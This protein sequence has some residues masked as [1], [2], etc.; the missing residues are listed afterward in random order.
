MGDFY[1]HPTAI[2]ESKNIGKNTRIW[3]FAHILKDV[4]V[5]EDCNL[6]DY[7]FVENGVSIGNR[8]TIKNGISIWNGV[9]IEDDVF[10]GPNCVLTNDIYPRSRVYH[11]E[12]IKTLFRQGAS[13]GAN[14]TVLCGIVLGRY[15]MVGAGSV[16]TKDVP[17][18]ALVVGSPA[19]FRYWIS[20]NGEKLVF[21]SGNYAK[22]S[23]GNGYKLTN[24][25]ENFKEYV[26]EE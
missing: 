20:K 25:P 10:L 12:N 1:I 24:N 7:T 15:C 21:N 4:T 16:V 23:T 14:A 18:Y 26:V 11:Q 9:T 17:D 6:C 8:V 5:G 22:D 3:A 13:I 19:K 2:C